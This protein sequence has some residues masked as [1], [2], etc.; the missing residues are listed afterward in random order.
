MKTLL[1]ITL[2]CFVLYNSHIM[3]H[4]I[5]AAKLQPAGEQMKQQKSA[6]PIM[7]RKRAERTAAN[8]MLYNGFKGDAFKKAQQATDAELYGIIKT[9]IIDIS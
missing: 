4:L 2:L 8:I 5:N 7:D 1:F 6:G 9:F 3:R